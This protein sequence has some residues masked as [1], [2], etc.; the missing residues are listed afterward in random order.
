M[1]YEVFVTDEASVQLFECASYIEQDSPEAAQKWVRSILQ[2]I[3]R[4]ANFPEAYPLALENHTHERELRQMA[5]GS[6]R[7]IFWI[8]GE[9]VTVLSVRHAARRPHPPGEL[10]ASQ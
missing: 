1:S 4:L 7:V 8:T 3:Y 6:Y 9:S 5:F 10:D 2:K